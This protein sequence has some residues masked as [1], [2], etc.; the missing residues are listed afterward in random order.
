MSKKDKI[1]ITREDEFT[2]ID[3]ELAEAMSLLEETNSRIAAMLQE[4][5][6]PET[7]GEGA[8]DPAVNVDLVPES[9]Q[10]A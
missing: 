5:A 6:K 1:S 9:G 10:D 2:E 8:L 4:H 7:Q 3:S